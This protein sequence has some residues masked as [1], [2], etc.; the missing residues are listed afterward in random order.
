MNGLSHQRLTYTARKA[1]A[2]QSYPTKISE[3]KSEVD[4]GPKKQGQRNC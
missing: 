1:S 4:V 3:L 2:E